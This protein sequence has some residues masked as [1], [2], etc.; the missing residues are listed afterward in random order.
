MCSADA[1]ALVAERGDSGVVTYNC[2]NGNG[3]LV[4]K[5]MVHDTQLD[6]AV[7]PSDMFN[8]FLRET[9]SYNRFEGEFAAVIHDARRSVTWA[10]NDHA[11]LLHLYYVECRGAVYIT[12]APLATAR[13]LG[14]GIDG[15][16]IREFLR[17]GQVM[18]PSSVFA[19]MRRLGLGEHLR[20][21]SAQV[22]VGKHWSPYHE[23]RQYESKRSAA[24]ATAELLLAVA[25]RYARRGPLICDLSGGYD[26]RLVASALSRSG[27]ALTVTVN[28]HPRHPDVV[29]AQRVAKA[30]DW[31]IKHYG[32]A[33]DGEM[34][35]DVRRAA[36]Y[37]SR[38]E[39]G[40]LSF[41]IHLT[42]RPALRQSFAAH[43]Q[44]GGGELLRNFPWG[45]EFAGIGQRRPANVERVLQYRLLAASPLPDNIFAVSFTRLLHDDLSAR[46]RA[47]IHDGA[48][49]LTTQQ[50]DA[51]YLLRLTGHTGGYT[52]SLYDLLP[53]GV[54]LMQRTVIDHAISLPWRM[55]LSA[56]LLRRTIALLHPKA[57]AL[58]TVYGAPAGPPEFRTLPLEVK[59]AFERLRHL[60][61]KIDR[62]VLGARLARIAPLT[63][64]EPKAPDPPFRTEEFRIFLDPAHMYSRG[65]YRPQPLAQL[66][67]DPMTSS[68]ALSR[69]ATVEHMCRELGVEV[70]PDL[71]T[72]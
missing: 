32:S 40:A 37:L 43:I 7:D 38:G 46:T 42:T 33:F 11:S 36:A 71:L 9:P 31:P 35:L 4:V 1:M 5:G 56:G 52:S 65:L 53:A 21:R 69:I 72:A 57:A 27:A 24:D 6:R 48:G 13:A 44:G 26:S 49:T 22:Q 3:W 28:G 25:A 18:C 8:A 17:R 14:L 58:E 55:R 70:G 67:A 51:A 50:L 19:T 66:L 20:L 29:V 59:Q 2:S 16:G 15:P 39:L 64:P 41:Y 45:Q 30:A 34:T 63:R 12:T 62:V 60:V 10:I 47:V 54:P 23:P 68:E 61:E